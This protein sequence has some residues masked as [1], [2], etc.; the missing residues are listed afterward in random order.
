MKSALVADFQAVSGSI[1][2]RVD[3]LNSLADA[4]RW[5]LMSGVILSL[6]TGCGSGA[7]SCK[8]DGDCASGKSC[9][10][11]VGS[12]SAVGQC[13]NEA[14]LGV[15]CEHFVS[16]CGCDGTSVP[17]LCGLDFAS[18]PTLGQDAPCGPAPT[19]VPGATLSTLAM[20]PQ[21]GPERIAVDA[22]N[23]YVALLGDG[24]I[25]KVPIAGGAPLT[26][27]SGQNQPTGIVVDA[28]NVYWTNQGPG[29]GGSDGPSVMK[30]SIAGGAPTILA[31]G[32]GAAFDIAVD[33]I[34]VY[35]TNLTGNHSVMVVPIAGGQPEVLAS[36]QG[37]WVVVAAGGVVYYTD[38]NDVMSVPAGGGSPALLATEPNGP[39]A[40][41][42]D[43]TNLYWSAFRGGGA[44]MKMPLAGGP[45]TALVP[46]T[47]LARIAVRGPN[48]YFASQDLGAAPNNSIVARVPTQGGA[49]TT[50][51]DGQS[52]AEGIAV[53]ADGV[54]WVD[55][56]VG[57]VMR[58]TPP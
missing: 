51:V 30:V 38:G 29:G 47:L 50:L 24:R 36:A 20:F 19:V 2:S 21:T 14:S 9:L 54:F 42:V 33:A 6:G 4:A 5:T 31:S 25:V 22:T 18:A 32:Q 15:R 10:Y 49:V 3:G 26:L 7:Q 57:A 35:W 16:Y 23:A 17:G 44:I 13:L 45:P 28:T 48:L 1:P 52:A 46:S 34:N 41:A 40:L 58:L 55:T 37:A 56:G 12:C 27:A 39:N 53:T 43:D 8:I 11:P